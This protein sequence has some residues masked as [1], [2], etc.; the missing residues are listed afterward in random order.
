MWRRWELVKG[1]GWHLR[2]QLLLRC[3]WLLSQL[4]LRQWRRDLSH[5][6]QLWL[7]SLD[8]LLKHSRQV[9][10]VCKLLEL[11]S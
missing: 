7:H 6:I 4:L 10:A 5:V 9:S 2:M 1:R 8:V 11:L 3:S